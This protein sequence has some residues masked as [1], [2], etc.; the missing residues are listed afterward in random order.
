MA[1][2]LYGVQGN[3]RG[4]GVRSLAV[5]RH[6]PEHEFLFVSHSQGAEFLRR[7][8][9]VLQLISPE[10][11]VSRH[12]VET[13]PMLYRNLRFWVRR[14][15]MKDS[16][17]EEVM[18]FDPEFGITDWEF[19]VPHLCRQLGIPCLSLDHQ[20]I[21]TSAIPGIPVRQWASYVGLYLS[22]RHVFSAAREYLVVSFFLNGLTKNGGAYKI[23]PPILRK[24]VL[25]LESEDRGH[26][27]SYQSTSTFRGYLPL[28]RAIRRPVIV[29]GQ[30]A[31]GAQ[32]N[33]RFKAPSEE[34]FLD[35]LRGCSYVICG[36]SHNLISEAL[37]LGK[38]VLA[39]P[40]AGL[41]EQYLNVHY[42]KRLGYGSFSTDYG[43]SPRLLAAF[44]GD[45]DRFRENIRGGR[46]CGNDEVFAA[47][48]RFLARG[49]MTDAP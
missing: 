15:A 26:V 20:H 3:G 38:P 18:R 1:R 10:T 48:D 37:H 30:H 44:E 40:I 6:Y 22:A 4:H 28:L 46:F 11:V 16:L 33:L 25:G 32:G 14:N 2:I 39:F 13:L 31:E 35:D 34:G 7:S 17:L 45:L 42:L 19:F 23:V 43:A 9:R 41:F 8:Y 36:G 24:P 21:V 47:V 27:L 49:T 5:A 29:Y 12:R